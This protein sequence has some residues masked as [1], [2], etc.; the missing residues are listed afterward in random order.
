MYFETDYSLTYITAKRC[1]QKKRSKKEQALDVT[2]IFYVIGFNEQALVANRS[3]QNIRI[4][5]QV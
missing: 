3:F 5:V 4:H 1:S 2:K